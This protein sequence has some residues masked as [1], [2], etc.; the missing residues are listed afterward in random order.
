MLRSSGLTYLCPAEAHPDLAG[1]TFCTTMYHKARTGQSVH[2]KLASK[3]KHI[4]LTCKVSVV[5]ATSH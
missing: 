3:P 2:L 4:K 5:T 1:A